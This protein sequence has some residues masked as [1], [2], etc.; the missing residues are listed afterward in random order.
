MAEDSKQGFTYPITASGYEIMGESPIGQG[1]FAE[2]R[3]G[4]VKETGEEV[5]IK[6]MRLENTSSS[7]EEIRVR[8]SGNEHIICV[9]SL[10][11]GVMCY[12]AC[13]MRFAP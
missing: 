1:A 8:V 10:I 4:R 7:L 6:I 2:V 12:Y 11:V 13:R 9:P 5:A 3:Y